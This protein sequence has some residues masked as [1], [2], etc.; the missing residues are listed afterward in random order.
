MNRVE[1]SI[2]MPWLLNLPVRRRTLA[3]AGGVCATAA[4][5]RAQVPGRAYR[6]GD[7]GFA[8]VAWSQRASEMP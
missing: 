4:I 1:E 5:A 3:A 8:V 6:I 7:L 2:E